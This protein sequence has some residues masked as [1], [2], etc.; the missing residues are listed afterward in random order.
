MTAYTA[1][2][3]G[4]YLDDATSDSTTVWTYR[5]DG[6]G[7]QRPKIAARPTAFT[8]RI[9]PYTGQIKLGSIVD[10]PNSS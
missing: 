5:E 2:F 3:R 6:G 10:E 8:E 1:Q 4:V 7:D 9:D